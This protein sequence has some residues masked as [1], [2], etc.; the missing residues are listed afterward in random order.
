MF[1]T[2]TTDFTPP[3]KAFQ[4]SNNRTITWALASLKKKHMDFVPSQL[5]V[6]YLLTNYTVS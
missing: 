1:V 6:T 5:Y 2:D 4:I 3:S